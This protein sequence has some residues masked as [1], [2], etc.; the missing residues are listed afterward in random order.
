MEPTGNLQADELS[1]RRSD[2]PGVVAGYRLGATLARDPWGNVTYEALGKGD[3]PVAIKLLAVPSPGDGGL[4][5]RF[6]RWLKVRASIRHPHLI[7]ILDWGTLGD[8]SGW[9][10]PGTDRYYVV[11]ELYRAPTL[12]EMIH[13]GPLKVAGCLRL[14][15]Q[16]ADALETVH[17]RGLVHRDLAPR[18]VVVEPR[19]GGQVLLGDFGLGAGA[20]RGEP[21]DSPESV[22]YVPPEALRN[23]PL[24]QES[25]VYSLACILFECLSGE[26]PYVSEL[27]GVVAFGH[28]AGP[29]PRLSERRPELPTAID[30]V[31]A[32]AMATDPDG[33]PG[34]PREFVSRAAEALESPI[35]PPAPAGRPEHDGFQ[36]D[37]FVPV[38]TFPRT[39]PPARR[40]FAVAL[41]AVVALAG[42]LGYLLGEAGEEPRASATADEQARVERSRLRATDTAIARLDAARAPARRRLA[43]ARTS[44]AQAR[45][46]ARLARAYR[47]AAA[48]LP[49]GTEPV[50]RALHRGTRAHRRLAV[51]ARRGERR[52]YRS[53][54]RAVRRS[55]R[56]LAAVLARLNGAGR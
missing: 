40:A 29:P 24:G 32:A 28:L 49:P 39:A 35:S 19:D 50:R 13:A 52:A 8:L 37:L 31:V 42:S 12:A 18:S 15:A 4:G 22:H 20:W 41:V 51:A 14:L 17:E 3:R 53:A 10:G 9:G 7:P 36:D 43:R 33:R 47:S 2:S 11:S 44:R 1:E 48:A 16:I 45:E 38:G 34:S 56:D 26:P 55:E 46:A 25:N 21:L 30:D 5:K 27:G 6:E 23:E 54:S